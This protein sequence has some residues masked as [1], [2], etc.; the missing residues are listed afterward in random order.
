M[1][2]ENVTK[3]VS[4]QKFGTYFRSNQYMQIQPLWNPN[5]IYIGRGSIW[6]HNLDLIVPCRGGPIFDRPGK[7]HDIEVFDIVYISIET[8]VS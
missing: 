3:S 6:L 7:V 4:L 2:M 1:R 8:I 5:V